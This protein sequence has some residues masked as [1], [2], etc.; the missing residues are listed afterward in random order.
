MILEARDTLGKDSLRSHLL[1]VLFEGRAVAVK[2]WVDS[3]RGGVFFCRAA[4]SRVSRGGPSAVYFVV[5]V[6]LPNGD[7]AGPVR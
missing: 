4:R 2:R 1:S 5:Q 7:A 3:G 6:G